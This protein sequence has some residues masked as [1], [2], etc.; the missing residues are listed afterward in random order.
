MLFFKEKK[1][2][3]YAATL[4]S[5]LLATA[6]AGG[7]KKQEEP[8]KASEGPGESSGN[9]D[10]DKNEDN[11]K[12][13]SFYAGAERTTLINSLSN[14]Q[15]TSHT[16]ATGKADGLADKFQGKDKK[17]LEARISAERSLLSGWQERAG[18]RYYQQQRNLL[19]LRWKRALAVQSQMM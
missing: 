18:R 5:L 13:A 15:L 6:C 11:G 14:N 2:G 1:N 17:S 12:P 16:I 3:M 4:A 8:V 7:E 19:N 10:S 9:G